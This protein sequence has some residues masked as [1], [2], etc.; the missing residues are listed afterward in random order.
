MK[1][2]MEN[3]PSI[4]TTICFIS[5]CFAWISLQNVQVMAAIVASIVAAI[6]GV[7]AGI[8]WYY[9]IQ[10]KRENIKRFKQ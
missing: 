7:L 9:S 8:N 5:T 2:K 6:S 3:N 1:S 4:Q 10:E